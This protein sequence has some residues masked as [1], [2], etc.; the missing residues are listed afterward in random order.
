LEDEPFDSVIN[1]NELPIENKSSWIFKHNIVELCTAVKAISFIEIIKK[2]SADKVFYFD[3]DM[4]V[5]GPLTSLTDFLDK[6]SIL[7]TPH[8]TEPEESYQAI[9]DNEI[10][11]LKHGTY[12]LGFLGV[13]NS[14]EGLRFLN[15]WAERLYGFCYADIPNGLFT[16]QKWIDLAPA[17]F[18][19]LHITREPVYNVATWNLTHRKATGTLTDGIQVNGKP[20]IFY[21]FSGFDSGDQ[22]VMLNRYIGDS[23]VLRDFR[24]W[25]IEECEKMGQSTYGIIKSVYDSYDNGESITKNQR[26]LYRNRQDL[27]KA[28]P[29][30]YST[31]DV[32]NSYY[33]WY[34]ANVQ[35]EM[36]SAQD[37]I[38]TLRSKLYDLKNEVDMI[39]SS[40]R[41]KLACFIG[42]LANKVRIK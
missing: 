13:R 29:Q 1:I 4:V 25:Y 35:D 3:P 18:E 10:C 41:W 15:W 19:D 30:P 22:E 11:S 28:F 39:K 21:H 40:R 7:L 38:E 9:V 24:Q 23:T 27:Q 26:L 5:T 20:L 36:E 12:N 31:S 2:Y 16:D 42:N 37:T 34:N 17:F 14:E 6:K 8:Q 33:H 32:D